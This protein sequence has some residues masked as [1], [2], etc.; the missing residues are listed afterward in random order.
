VKGG[1]RVRWRSGVVAL[2]VGA[3]LLIAIWDFLFARH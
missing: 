3:L 1:R 2:G